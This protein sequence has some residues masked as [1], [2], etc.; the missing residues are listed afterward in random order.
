[1]DSSAQPR[2]PLGVSK[3]ELEQ[4]PHETFRRLRPLTPLIRRDDGGYIAIRAADVERLM[5]DPR[6]RQSETELPTSRGV[7][8]GALFTFFKSSMLFTNGPDH[9][10]R[11]APLSRV[12]AVKLIADLRPRI[13]AVAER[14][15]D[16]A[17]A[18]KEMNLLDDY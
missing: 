11:R 1:M 15:V 3:T 10:R 8:D 17:S 2:E 9:R 18:R 16:R 12:F 7:T 14:L 13:R 6:T 5:T 4:Q